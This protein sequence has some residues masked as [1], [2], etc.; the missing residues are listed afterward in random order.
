MDVT[1]PVEGELYAGLEEQKWVIDLPH[2][3]GIGFGVL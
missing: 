1:P 2:D 3:G